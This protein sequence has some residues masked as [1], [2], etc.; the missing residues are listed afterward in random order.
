MDRITF[1][2][3]I[4]LLALTSPTLAD[5]DAD[6]APTDTPAPKLKNDLGVALDGLT[7]QQPKDLMPGNE[8]LEAMRAR[9]KQLMKEREEKDQTI[10]SEERLAQAYEQTFVKLWD[11]LRLSGHT[12]E[13]FKTFEFNLITTGRPDAPRTLIEGVTESR[14]DQ[15]PRALGHVEWQGLVDQFVN[16]GYRVVQSEWHHAR[17]DTD[18]RGRRVSTFNITIDLTHDESDTRL[19]LT[20][21]I[22]IVWTDGVNTDGNPRPGSIDTTGLTLLTRSGE[23]MFERTVLGKMPFK[24]GYDDVLA[25]DLNS[26]GLIDIVYTNAN[27]VLFNRGNGFFNREVLC[28]HPF[29]MISEAAFADFT[30]DGVVD[31]LVAGTNHSGPSSP[32]RYGLF[33][34]KGDPEGRF[35]TPATVAIDPDAAPLTMPSA[36]AIGDID[37]DGDLDLWLAQ[38]KAAYAGGNF[39]TPYYDANDGF[40]GYLL[41]NNGDGTFTDATTG[42]GLEAKRFRR[43]FRASLADLDDDGDLDLLVVS[44]FAGV[45]LFYN[46]GAGTFTDVTDTVMAVPTNFGMGLTFDDFDADGSLD[47]YVTG[48]AST[49]ARRL[50]QM[51]LGNP[52]AEAHNDQRLVI[53]YGNRMYLG[54]GDGR[55]VEPEFRDQIARSGWSWGVA[56]ADFNN[57]GYPDLYIANGNKSRATAKDYCTRFW[58]HDIYSGNSNEDPVQFKVFVDELSQYSKEGTS[59]NGFEHNHLFLNRA[60]EGFTNAG[61]MMGAAMEQDSRAVLAHDFDNDGRVDLLV[62]TRNLTTDPD[63][64]QLHLL[65]NRADQTGRH[66]VGVRLTGA[67]GVSP[68]GAKVTVTTVNGTRANAVLSGDSFNAQHA[69]VLHFGLGET[70][71]VTRIE[72]RW[73]NGEV[74]TLDTPAVD[75]YHDITPARVIHAG[76]S[77]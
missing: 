74:T 47:F 51:G 21:P 43:A 33:L 35:T 25:Q 5:G 45:D 57:D 32:E 64:F 56:S 7:G 71:A 3:V 20:G 17:F 11:D 62:S 66:W 48:M 19:T 69:P 6:P 27:L 46:N 59:W 58:C 13:H 72:V 9:Y 68:L 1:S 42:S 24:V 41:I 67:T 61:F 12:P 50:A 38:Y 49:T 60:G 26:D 8:S 75:T 77:P 63:H 36:M 70:Q 73:P 2:L 53:A 28:K 65:R 15:S 37:A 18:D 30:G 76:V 4:C 52:N 31:Y 34:Y 54:R 44:D 10:W 14:L 22:Q 39:P 23:P 29:R 40:P 16:A 55:F